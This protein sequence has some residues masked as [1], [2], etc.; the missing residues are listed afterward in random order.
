MLPSGNYLLRIAPAATRAT[1]NDTMS[2]KWT[3][4]AGHFDGRDGALVR[5][6]A[7]CPIEEVQGFGRSYWTLI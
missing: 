1:A 3:N 6:R 2:K 7:H 5:Y 4:F